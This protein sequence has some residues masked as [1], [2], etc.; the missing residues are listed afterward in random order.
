MALRQGLDVAQERP[1][2]AGLE[3]VS[4]QVEEGLEHRLEA[5]ERPIDE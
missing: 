2:R 4:D 5:G 3:V 1:E